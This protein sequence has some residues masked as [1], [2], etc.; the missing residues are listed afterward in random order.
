MKLYIKVGVMLLC[1]GL[2]FIGCSI[3]SSDVDQAVNPEELQSD[4]NLSEDTKSTYSTLPTVYTLY[5]DSAGGLKANIHGYIVNNGGAP[6]TRC[7]VAW[8]QY[9][10]IGVAPTSYAYSSCT[11]GM[12]TCV[13]TNLKT[14][15]IYYARAFAQ[16]SNGTA[17][18]NIL[19]FSI[20]PTPAPTPAQTTIIETPRTPL[21]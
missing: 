13:T 20:S 12:F 1:I 19:S 10:N 8:S 9:P 18:G 14:G 21:P 6:I 15:T 17:Y 2:F 3:T 11:S 4:T 5:V 7:G 16:N